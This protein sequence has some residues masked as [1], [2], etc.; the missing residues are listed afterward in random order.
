MP[1]QALYPPPGPGTPILTYHSLDDSG[2][3][4]SV[5][6]PDFAAH[7]RSLAR[8]GFAG[9][10]LA[11]LLDGWDG[12]ARLPARPVVLTFD[13]GFAN[14]LQHAV[15]LLT[16]LGFRATVFAVS[17]RCGRTNDWPH[18]APGI[19][20]L[21]LL[22]W[23]EL[24]QVEA[25]GFEIGAHT[26]THRPLTELPPAEAEREM[27]ESKAAIEDR[28]GKPVKTFAY[29]FGRFSRA[30][31]EVARAHF[32]GACSVRLGRATPADDRHQLPRLDIYYMRRPALFRL[33]ETPPGRAYLA[34]RGI[35]RGVRGL[36]YRNPPV[37]KPA[38]GRC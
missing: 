31:H 21:P 8:R 4:T 1:D 15:P 34:L 28:L 11:G 36:L 32:R 38:D 25:A 16:E 7:M 19:P 12:L 10:S 13:D 23:A 20:R 26:V 17:G 5:A 2:A 35:G 29:P 33:F 9:I 22:S 24:A 14:L 6:P 30:D 18:Q 3:V 27:V 37:G